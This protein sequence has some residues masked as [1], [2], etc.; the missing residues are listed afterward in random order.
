[1]DF[2][3]EGPGLLDVALDQDMIIK[4]P[5]TISVLTFNCK[6]MFWGPWRRG[7]GSSPTHTEPGPARTGSTL[8]T[9]SYVTHQKKNQH[10]DSLQYD[11]RPESDDILATLAEKSRQHEDLQL[12]IT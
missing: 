4:C 12:K 1:M 6:S 11:T 3:G 10:E 5:R 7:D 9:M 8:E 2:R